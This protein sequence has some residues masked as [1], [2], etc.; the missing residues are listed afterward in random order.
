MIP[1]IQR[2]AVKI[3]RFFMFYFIGLKSEFLIQIIA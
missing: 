3:V 1:K 2:V